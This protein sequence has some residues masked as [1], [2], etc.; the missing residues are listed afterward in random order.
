MTIRVNYVPIP[1]EKC[2][3]VRPGPAD[4]PSSV[5]DNLRGKGGHY[6]ILDARYELKLY[7]CL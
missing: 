3:I 5:T 7:L 2:F 6:F 1:L 4:R